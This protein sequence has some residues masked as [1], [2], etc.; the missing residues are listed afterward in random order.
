MNRQNYNLSKD[1]SKGGE[2]EVPGFST[3]NV[4]PTLERLFKVF[5]D[6]QTKMEKFGGNQQFNSY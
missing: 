5:S 2:E 4:L 6:N 3:Q 1:F